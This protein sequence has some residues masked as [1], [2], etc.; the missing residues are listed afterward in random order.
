[1][2]KKICILGG[3]GFVG[4]TL[5]TYLSNAGYDVCIPTRDRE[6]KRKRQDLILIP[7]VDLI[8][9]DIYVQSNLEAVIQDCDIVINLVGI[10]N[11]KGRNGSG[12]KRAHVELTEQVIKACK[13]CGVKR[14]LHMSALN[15]DANN[16]P[17]HYLRTKGMA[18]DLVHQ[19]EGLAVTSFQP[20]VIFGANDSFFNRFAGLLK[21]TPLFF[22]LACANAKFAPVFI[23]DVAEAICRSVNNRQSYGKKY[24]LVGPGVYTLQELVAYTA[25]CLGISRQVIALPDFLARLQA[26][27]FDFVPGKPFSTDNYL[28]AS[29]DSVSDTNDL[30]T[31]GIE[32]TPL[33]SVVPRYL[34]NLSYRAAYYD[35]RQGSRRSN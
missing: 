28:S 29:E 33:E 5:A 9:T 1:M 21:I 25:K 34:T 10:L 26:M 18:E 27:V 13:S 8:D 15:A 12:F 32:P 31:L 24:V 11:E 6:G 7:T 17:S 20:S 22:P 23:G 3:A 19:A 30:L 2:N 35:Y 4:K 16:G 14:L